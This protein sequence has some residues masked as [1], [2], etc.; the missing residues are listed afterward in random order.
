MSKSFKLIGI[1]A[2]LIIGFISIT[3]YSS[4]TAKTPPSAPVMPAVSVSVQT[5]E[6]QKILIWSSFS[7]R[8]Q[9]VD[10]A[11]IRP[12]VSG[13]ITE[14]RFKDGDI[15]KAGDVLMV[16]DPQ[17]YE[18]AVEKA[19]ANLVSATTKAEFASKEF[20][21]SSSLIKSQSISQRNFDQSANDEKVAQADIKV[22]QAE[23]TQAKINL[24]HAYVKAP[25][26]G[27]VSRAEITVG[28]LVDTGPNAPVLTSIVSNDGIYA[29]FE[30][31]EQTYLKSIRSHATTSAQEQSI[32][33]ELTVLGDEDH[34]YKGTIYSFDNKIDATSGTIRAR[35]KFDNAD[36][37]LV[38]GMFVSVKLASS[39]QQNVILVPERAI[40][41]DQNKKYVYVVNNDNKV[42]YR[43]VSL[44]QH[45]K[46][47][48]RIVLNGLTPGERVIVDGLQHVQPD[49]VVQ[50]KEIVT[51]S[52]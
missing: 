8:M 34:V 4:S 11:Q 13:R 35:A 46:E 50:I 45:A 14:I 31:D 20:V 38:P 21:R 49:I 36:G 17:P 51:K 30:V 26:S 2:I 47:G 48:L 18:A 6:P 39:N 27:R 32:P 33:V 5:I 24:S 10:Y 12:E 28:N 16:I 22:A 23:L 7:G 3:S 15:V 42:A 43:E 9:P 19:Q 44:G 1:F 40:A 52:R 41:N 25:I 29:D 37:S